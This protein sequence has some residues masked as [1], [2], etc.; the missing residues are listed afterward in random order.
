MRPTGKV[1]LVGKGFLWQPASRMAVNAGRKVALRNTHLR[2]WRARLLLQPDWPML[3]P[4][5][6][7]S[8][9]SYDWSG[10]S[11]RFSSAT[12]IA[13]AAVSGATGLTQMSVPHS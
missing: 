11:A 3:S 4:D 13:R 2:H 12:R 7:V 1:W 9:L 5:R 10:R 6:A 8:G